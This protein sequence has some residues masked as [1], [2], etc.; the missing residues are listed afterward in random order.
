MEKLIIFEEDIWGIDDVVRFTTFPVVSSNNLIIPFLLL[1]SY[2]SRKVHKNGGFCEGYV[3]TPTL[4]IKKD[5]NN[6]QCI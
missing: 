5:N 3:I 2:V 4:F 6:Q 1:S